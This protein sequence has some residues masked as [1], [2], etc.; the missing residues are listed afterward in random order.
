MNIKQKFL[1]LTS[2]TVPNGDED[3]VVKW[4]PKGL[5]KDKWGNYFL[6]IGSSRTIFTSHLDTVSY[7][8][9]KVKH[10]IDGDIIKTDG[11]ST[12]GADDKA[13]VTVM[14]YMIAK[15]VPG[16]Y[17][18][19]VGEE[20]GCIGSGKASKDTLR[21]NKEKFDRMVSFDRRDI[22]SVITYQSGQR[23]CSEN[24]ALSLSNKLNLHGLNL[25]PDNTGVYTDSAKFMGIIPE[26]TNI[27]VGYYNEHSSS[28]RQDIG[29]LFKLCKAVVKI[30]WESLP[31][32]RNP[33]LSEYKS[34]NNYN[35]GYYGGYDEY[36][37]HGYGQTKHNNTPH[38]WDSQSLKP[39]YNGGTTTSRNTF[40]DDELDDNS[41]LTDNSSL[42]RDDRNSLEKME[43][44]LFF[45]SGLERRNIFTSMKDKFLNDELTMDDIEVI[46]YQ[47]LDMTDPDDID[48]IAN[49]EEL[50]R[51]RVF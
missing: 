15:K 7:T 2:I 41:W 5:K 26:C 23:C 21:F 30:D 46:K 1:K 8:F 44:R 18:F 4:L 48:F 17:Y 51:C 13:G 38:K 25:S 45:A 29:Y 40:R 49:I 20:S 50:N 11:N 36:E 22:C 27:S 32:E 43:E 24:F 19:F 10:V 16:L 47:M 42:D 39:T 12:L 34:Y 14:L 33:L 35:G 6:Q 37:Y 9:K 3:K 28:E 31:T